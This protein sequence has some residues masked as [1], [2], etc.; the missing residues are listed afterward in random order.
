[1]LCT[2]GVFDVMTHSEFA[3]R[4]RATTA[5]EAATQLTSLGA[6]DDATVLVV[7][8]TVDR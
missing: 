6:S 5:A 8:I 2:D 7:D 3:S 1:V 4:A